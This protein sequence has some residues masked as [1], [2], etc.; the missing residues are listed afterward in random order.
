MASVS[1]IRGTLGGKPGEGFTPWDVLRY[2]AALGT[3]LQKIGHRGQTIVLGR[4]ARPSGGWAAQLVGAT[5]QAMGFRVLD[6]GLSTTP[7][8]QMEVLS[9]QAA[10]GI[11][12]SASHNPSEWNALKLFNSQGEFIAPAVAAEIANLATT[13]DFFFADHQEQGSA[14]LQAGAIDRHIAAILALSLVDGDAIRAKKFRVALDAVNSTGGLALIPLLE[15]LG[16]AEIVPLHCEATGIFAHPPEPLPEH[17]SE[18]CTCVKEKNLDLGIAVDPDVDRLALVAEN[19]IPF[20]EEYTLVS[21]ADYVLQRTPGPCVSNLSS[22]RALQDVAAWHRQPYYAAAVGEIHVVQ[23]MRATEAVIGGEGNGGVIYPTLHAGRD[24]LVGAA[25]FL[26]HLAHWK[27]RASAL[28]A[29]YPSYYMRKSKIALPR[30]AAVSDLLQKIGQKY[31]QQPQ[32]HVDGLRIDFPKAWIHVRPS[33]TEPILRLHTEAA[34]EEEAQA[35]EAQSM[36]LLQAN[37]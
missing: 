22:S 6:T 37:V 17:L 13:Q 3:Y 12:L 35:L 30:P 24:A 14:Q 2:T 5:L 8:T 10:G 18:L 32:Q 23:K 11:M 29:K 20:G 19:G 34:N 16:V 4:D 27:G 7:T 9:A 26:S 31:A 1:G 28:R 25:L 21:V 36:A 15:A 33:N